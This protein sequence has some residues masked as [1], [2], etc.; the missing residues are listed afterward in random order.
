[1]SI[2]AEANTAPTTQSWSAWHI[3]PRHSLAQFSVRHMM[4]PKVIEIELEAVRE[5]PAPAADAR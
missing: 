4:L 1:M 5:D 3:D 2:V